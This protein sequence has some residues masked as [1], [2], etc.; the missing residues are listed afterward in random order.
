MRDDQPNRGPARWRDGHRVILPE[1]IDD[2]TNPH[3]QYTPRTL[4]L[5]KLRLGWSV[6][7]TFEHREHRRF[8]AR[9]DLEHTL[10]CDVLSE[11]LPPETVTRTERQHVTV[12]A[13]R[14]A[15][16]WDHAKA[17]YA[18]RWWAAWYVRRRPPQTVT[19][20]ATGWVT[21]TATV[22]LERFW[23][24]PEA[25]IRDPNMGTP[26]RWSNWY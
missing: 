17:T 16:W 9:Q 24:Y 12:D 8:D 14:W 1:M 22:N 18:G 21:A 10:T 19:V 4:L 25:S 23:T 3:A 7:E 11:R 2:W 13:P 5:E 6:R 15:T 26:L 20:P